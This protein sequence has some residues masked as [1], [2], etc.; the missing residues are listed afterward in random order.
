MATDEVEESAELQA[1]RKELREWLAANNLGAVGAG[2][3]TSDVAV[4]KAWQAA[5]YD[6]GYVDV[7]PEQAAVVSEELGRLNVFLGTF[8]VGMSMTRP[9]I[10]THGTDEQKAR[11]LPPLMRG[12]EIWCQLFSEPGAGS[13]LAGLACRAERDGDEWVINGQKVWTSG[14][15]NSDW[16]ILMARTDWDVPKHRGISYF[17]FPMHQDGVEIRPLRQMT[18]AAHF[19]EVFLTDAR[20][21]DANILGGLNNGWAVGMTT[22]ANERVAIGGGGGRGSVFDQLLATARS[23]GRAGDPVVR[24][25]LAAAYSRIEL[26]RW[27]GQR[28]GLATMT[29]KLSYA[30]HNKALGEL[31]LAL[32]GPAGALRNE[33]TDS[34]LSAPSIRIAGGSDEV[35]R[36][37]L[38]ERVLGLPAEPRPDK[39][40]PFRDLPRN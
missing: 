32:Q 34:F 9:T 3:G 25:Q 36:N 14:A 40:A 11:F 15:Q 16:G 27:L 22:L 38:G 20:V 26:I 31:A 35:Q 39:T 10:V 17:L 28:G 5:L 18:G 29:L 2:F 30:Q 23:H 24:Q 7:G 6:A 8:M 4:A 13:D 12:D 33:W 21:P 1:F 19:N 37:I